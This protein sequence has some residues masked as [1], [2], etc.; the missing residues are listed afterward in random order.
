MISIRNL[1]KLRGGRPTLS[2]VTADVAPG[3]AVAIVGSSGGGKTTLLRCLSCLDSFDE[4][5]IR[6]A[7]F[8]LQPGGSGLAQ[9]DLVRLRSAVGFV[10]Q[11]LHLF[12][13]LS[14]LDNITL[15]PKV[16]RHER[17]K[18]AARRALDL[19]EQVGLRDRA[20]AYPHELSGGQ[21]QRVAI[22]RALAQRP[23]VLLLDE[24]TSAL[25]RG[26]AVHTARAISELTR[27][28]VTLV[29]VTHHLDLASQM[30][31]RVLRLEGGTLHDA[32]LASEPR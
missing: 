3:E 1:H 7:G 17:A 23:S 25:D 27:G 10:F 4:G 12:S 21:K 29:L 32:G 24:P 9:V 26:T 6:I 19:L 20:G 22:V 18:D 8:E 15:A 11:E 31:D 16:V 2:G 13:H 28:R 30:A 14:V 5:S